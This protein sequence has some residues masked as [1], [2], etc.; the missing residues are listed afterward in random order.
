MHKEINIT[1][2]SDGL[3]KLQP[4]KVDK[5]KETLEVEQSLV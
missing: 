4:Y 1:L 2:F 5:E 3:I